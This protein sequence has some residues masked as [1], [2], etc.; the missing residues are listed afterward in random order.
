MKNKSILILIFLLINGK[1]YAQLIQPP[2]FFK[3]LLGHWYI[4][5]RI[6]SDKGNDETIYTLQELKKFKAQGLTFNTDSV[7][8]FLDTL[9]SPK[10]KIKKVNSKKYLLETFQLTKKNFAVKSDSLL[11]VNIEGTENADNGKHFTTY[12]NFFY[13]GK[14][15]YLV[16]DMTIFRLFK[17]GLSYSR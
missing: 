16:E 12:Y 2:I 8:L 7:K 11:I 14:Y 15:L 10:Y 1:I 5:D 6:H 17:P 3:Q 13:D 4:K 9:T